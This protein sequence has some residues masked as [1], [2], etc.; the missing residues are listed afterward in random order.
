M[1]TKA[2]LGSLNVLNHNDICK[3]FAQ[4]FLHPFCQ[5]FCVIFVEFDNFFLPIHEKLAKNA[6]AMGCEL[7]PAQNILTEYSAY[8]IFHYL[9][10]KFVCKALQ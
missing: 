8:L 6:I 7:K 4:D 2:T 3:T 9:G 10:C 5:N 1:N